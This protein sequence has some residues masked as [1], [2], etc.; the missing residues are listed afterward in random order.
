MF[1]ATRPSP[2]RDVPCVHC[3]KLLQLSAA[4]RNTTCPHCYRGMSFDHVAIRGEWTGKIATGGSVTIE[5]KS[6][7]LGRLVEASGDI[8]V[9]GAC[10][11]DW[12]TRGTIFVRPGGSLRGHVHAA[13]VVVEHG[14]VLT[15][16]V[17]I[18]PS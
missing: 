18:G 15:G 5:P 4:A 9:E 3:G 14:G 7:A 10:E 12:R 2:V 16:D 6:V 11:G 13:A 8:V 17:R 1:H